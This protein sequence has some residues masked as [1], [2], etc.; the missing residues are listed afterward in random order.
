MTNTQADW[1]YLTANV[2]R[3]DGSYVGT[4]ETVSY[5]YGGS[6]KSNMVA[7]DPAGN[8]QWS[9]GTA[10]YPQIATADG[11]VAHI[12]RMTHWC[13]TSARLWQMWDSPEN[14]YKL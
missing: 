2:Q 9:V 1:L 13:P 8:F 4:L 3:A 6:D 10:Y 11:L 5:D 12:S 14:S 7:F